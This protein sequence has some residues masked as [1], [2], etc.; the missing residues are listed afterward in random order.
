MN[1]KYN[2]KKVILLCSFLCFWQLGNCQT[3]VQILSFLDSL[4]NGGNQPHISQFQIE[5]LCVNYPIGDSIRYFIDFGDGHD[6]LLRE[7]IVSSP[8]NYFYRQIFHTYDSIGVFNASLRVR[9]PDFKSDTAYFLV[10][11]DRFAISNKSV[12]GCGSISINGNT[13]NSSQ[14]IYDTLYANNVFEKDSVIITNLILGNTVHITQDLVDCDSLL[15]NNN[16]YHTTQTVVDT[17]LSYTGCDSIITYNLIV[18]KTEEVTDTLSDCD[19]ILYNGRVYYSDQL[20]IDTLPLTSQGC[21]S[22][23]FTFIDIY[24]NKSS[25]VDITIN[26]GD[27]IFIGGVYLFDWGTYHIPIVAQ[28][29]CDSI[30]TVNVS[31]VSSIGRDFDKRI[32]IFLNESQQLNIELLEGEKL[33]NVTIYNSLGKMFLNEEEI[34]KTFIYDI[35]GFYRG[36]YVVRVEVENSVVLKKIIIN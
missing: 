8:N 14:I 24:Q 28:N 3:S 21:D 7:M 36:V 9:M 23:R 29:G 35:S 5:G 26:R 13:Y 17:F 4:H 19:S 25:T 15:F 22:L 31:L 11:S 2:I 16:Y 30:V 12:I 32:K 33:K 34:D 27:S 20:V 6:T 18:G 10:N 1:S